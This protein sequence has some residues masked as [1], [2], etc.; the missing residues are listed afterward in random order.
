MNSDSSIT[1]T[2]PSE[3]A[4][5]VDITVTNE[6]GTSATSSADQFTFQLAPTISVISPSKGPGGT[7]VTL[8]GTHFENVTAITFDGVEAV[9]DIVSD[10]QINTTSPFTDVTGLVDVVITTSGGSFTVTNGYEYDYEPT[11]ANISPS[12]GSPSGGTSVT[13]TGTHFLGATGVSFGSTAAA[14]FSITNDTTIVATSPVGVTGS[15]VDVTVT[16]DYGTSTTS[17]MDKF[18]YLNASTVTGLSPNSGTDG[19]GVIVSGTD[20]TSVSAVTFGATPATSFAIINSTT[21][22]AIAP[23]GAGTVDVTVTTPG[24]TSAISVADQ[25]TYTSISAE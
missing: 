1:V 12:A 6:T 25:F 4:G 24:G 7:A 3:S 11:V 9:Y 22:I 19:T 20:F 21:L 23:T 18:T 16:T 2:S 17:A 15:V 14:S 13:I 8:T 5:T 10:T